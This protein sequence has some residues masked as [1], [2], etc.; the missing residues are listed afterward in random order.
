ML[1]DSTEEFDAE[2]SEDV[3]E[4]EEEQS[5]IADLG[6]RLHHRVEKHADRTCHFQQLEH[7]NAHHRAR[8]TL[9]RSEYRLVHNET[10]PHHIILERHSVELIPAPRPHKRQVTHMSHPNLT[11]TLTP[12]NPSITL[13]PT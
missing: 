4:K 7:C 2:R 10:K 5:E 8:P 6:Q 11:L 1:T 12:P 13:T 9:R 3:E